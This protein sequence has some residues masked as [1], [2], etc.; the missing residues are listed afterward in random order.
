[1]QV[2]WKYGL[3]IIILLI[4]IGYG[5]GRYIQPAKIVTKTEIVVKE[6]V[7]TVTV[8]VTKPDGTKTTTTTQDDDKSTKDKSSTVTTQDKPSWKV[9]GLAGLSLNSLTTPVYGGQIERR[10]IGPVS[11]GVWGLTNSTGGVL[12]SIEF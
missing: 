11:V 5:I 12:L 4:G 6:H 7:H 3:G 1:M 9:A 8:T 10:I 2:N